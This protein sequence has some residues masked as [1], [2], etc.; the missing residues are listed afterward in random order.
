MLGLGFGFRHSVAFPNSH[1]VRFWQLESLRAKSFKGSDESVIHPR[2][3]IYKYCE[4]PES[5]F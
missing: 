2:K 4:K 5:M 3:A 1:P